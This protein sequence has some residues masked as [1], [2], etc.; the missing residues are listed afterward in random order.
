MAPKTNRERWGLDGFERLPGK[1]RKK[2]RTRV[3]KKI[4]CSAFGS[5]TYC[6]V[7]GIYIGGAFKKCYFWRSWIPS[8]KFSVRT[9]RQGHNNDPL[10]LIIWPLTLP[11]IWWVA[12]WPLPHCRCWST[13][14]LRS[15][16]FSMSSAAVCYFVIVCHWGSVFWFCLLMSFVLHPKVT[17]KPSSFPSKPPVI[18]VLISWI[19]WAGNATGEYKGCFPST[20]TRR[21]KK[22]WFHCP[23]PAPPAAMALAELKSLG[24]VPKPVPHGLNLITSQTLTMW[25]CFVQ[26]AA[27]VRKKNASCLH[28][29]ISALKKLLCMYHC[30]KFRE[31]YMDIYANATKINKSQAK[32]K[33]KTRQEVKSLYKYQLA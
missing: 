2:T 12:G 32:K 28:V 13:A 7:F 14:A 22:S 21:P 23:G 25:I 3:T 1:P 8:L 26:Q 5:I 30:S 9:L 10:W 4:R 11:K 27:V 6:K 31:H 19:I 24:S 29:A 16:Q 18:H 33:R 17:P 15:F 20:A